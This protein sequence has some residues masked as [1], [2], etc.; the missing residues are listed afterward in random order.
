[1]DRNA[2]VN[3]GFRSR[4][5]VANHSP[6]IQNSGIGYDNACYRSVSSARHKNMVRLKTT[7]TVTVA[8]LVSSAAF[9]AEK[10][11]FEEGTT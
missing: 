3:P 7:W 6:A 9:A 10:P 8:L 1:V 5:C 4:L 11:S 2:A